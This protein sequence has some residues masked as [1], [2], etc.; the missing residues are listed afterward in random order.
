MPLSADLYQ[1]QIAITPLNIDGTQTV[2]MNLR[3]VTVS[4]RYRVLGVWRTYTL[5]TFVSAYS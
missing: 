4:V 1:R 5:T 3:Q 2:N